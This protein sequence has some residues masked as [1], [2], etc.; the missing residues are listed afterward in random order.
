MEQF[1]IGNIV[2][3]YD[4]REITFSDNGHQNF[5]FYLKPDALADLMDYFNSLIKTYTQKRNA[6]RI[7][8]NNSFGLSVLLRYG[9]KS[10]SVKPLNLSLTGILIEFEGDDVYGMAK[11]D[12]VELSIELGDKSENMA[13]KIVRCN[14][15]QYGIFFPETIVDGEVQAPEF[16]LNIT[17]NLEKRWLRERISE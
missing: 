12:I 17:S 8:L 2:I 1:I 11:G 9:D 10:C 14:H 15:P 5:R 7:P 16:L 13:G 6:F 3:T 4:G